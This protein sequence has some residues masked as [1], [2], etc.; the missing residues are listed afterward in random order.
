MMAILMLAQL[1]E[2]FK[3]V[4]DHLHLFDEAMEK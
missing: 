1:R 2:G 3:I 4:D